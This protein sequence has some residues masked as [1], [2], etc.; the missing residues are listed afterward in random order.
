MVYQKK[1]R[2]RFQLFPGESTR[3]P[4]RCN[5]KIKGQ[6]YGPTAGSSREQGHSSWHLHLLWRILSRAMDIT[7]HISDIKTTEK[8]IKLNKMSRN[9]PYSLTPMAASGNPIPN[10]L[11]RQITGEKKMPAFRYHYCHN[12][13]VRSEQ[14][15]Y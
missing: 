6:R 4:R 5:G 12:R 11:S 8:Y 14:I 13:H 3:S 1:R 9:L 10:S 7:R 15:E 2:D